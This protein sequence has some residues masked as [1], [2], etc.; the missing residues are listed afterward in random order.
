MTNTLNGVPECGNLWRKWG[1]GHVWSNNDLGFSRNDDKRESSDL[2]TQ[3]LRKINKKL[4]TSK[5][6]RERHMDWI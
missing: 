1:S 5:N 2:R 3:V 4:D 6:S